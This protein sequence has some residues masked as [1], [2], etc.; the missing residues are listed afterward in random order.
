MVNPKI[1]SCYLDLDLDILAVSTE[2]QQASCKIEWHQKQ[3]SPHIINAAIWLLQQFYNYVV[4]VIQWGRQ[5]KPGQPEPRPPQSSRQNC[6][7]FG[8]LILRKIGKITAIF[9]ADCTLIKITL[10][11]WLS[12]VHPFVNHE[13]TMAK[14]CK[15]G[16]RLL[17]ITRTHSFPSQSTKFR[18]SLRQN[19]SN[20]TAY[21]VCPFVNKLSSIL[22]INFSY[23][24]LSLCSV[25]LATFKENYQSFFLFKS[26]ICHV[27]LNCVYL[28]LCAVLWRL[29][30]ELAVLDRLVWFFLWYS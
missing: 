3:K 5:R 24:N 11:A 28:W 14:R 15:I 23:W 2:C 16:P 30:L 19:C 29:L 12:S 10:L 27:T 1:R 9:L 20:S 7:K 4:Y 26:A 8:H 18:S 17:L 13:C 21:Y 22:C 25:M 6:T